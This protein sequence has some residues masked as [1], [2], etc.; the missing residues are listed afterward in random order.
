MNDSLGSPQSVLVLGG[1]SEIARAVV[2]EL[3]ARRAQRVVLAG[4]PSAE[5][6]EAAD[7][8][9]SLGA[10]DVATVTLE[11]TDIDTIPALIDGVFQAHGD[12]DLVLM[13][14]GI[15]GD[16]STDEADP[17]AAA[18]V[19]TTNFTG[20]AAACLA[21]AGR[22]RS[23]GHGTL[24][25]LSTVAGE[26]VRRAN[27]V[28]GSSKAG[29]DGFCQ[30]LGDSLVGSGAH[31]LIVRPGFVHTRM[32]TGMP[33]APLSTTA[34]Q[35]AKVVVS[36]LEKKADVVWAPPP[37]RWLMVVMRHLPRVVWRRIPR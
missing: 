20:P 36:G 10:T 8:A 17:V 14:V 16:Q 25:V 2:R 3:V 34:D 7:E 18:R 32:T 37:F 22:L 9:R 28:Y 31:L 13:A 6:E 15:L 30:G 1:S 11:I 29:L 26:R 23:Q 5:L 33:A 35:V 27:F 24:A 21:V 4:R 19:I 12:F